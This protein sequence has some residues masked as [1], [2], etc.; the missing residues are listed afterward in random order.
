MRIRRWRS[1]RHCAM[2]AQ[3]P[4]TINNMPERAGPFAKSFFCCFDTFWGRFWE[5][6]ARSLRS[7]FGPILVE[8][9]V[10]FW[11]QFWFHFWFQFWVPEFVPNIIF[12]YGAPNLAPILGTKTGTKIGTK[13]GPRAPTLGTKAG[14][15]SDTKIGTKIGPQGIQKSFEA[16]PPGASKN[17]PRKYEPIE[18]ISQ[19]GPPS[20]AC[21]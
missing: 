7:L 21:C 14:T 10:Q 13:I 18:T 15:K 17:V 6:P 19:K 4:V 20:P 11:F 1:I 16:T 8:L 5:R 3:K 9:G 2:R 12:I